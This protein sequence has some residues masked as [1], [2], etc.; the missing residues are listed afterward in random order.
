[1]LSQ[2]GDIRPPFFCVWEGRTYGPCNPLRAVELCS[3]PRKFFEKNLTKNFSLSPPKR[4]TYVPPFLCMGR[5][6][7]RSR[8]PLKVL[9][10]H[11]KPHKPFEK[12]L[13]ENFTCLHPTCVEGPAL[14]ERKKAACP[15]RSRTAVR[16]LSCGV[17]RRDLSSPATDLSFRKPAR[18]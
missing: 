4:G 13:S 3:T 5:Q 15:V 8:T 1:M 10:F 2:E 9:G 6:D 14:A 11:P 18:R 17:T 7:L 12:G 16:D